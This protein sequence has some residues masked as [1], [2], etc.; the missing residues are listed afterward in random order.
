MT[1]HFYSSGTRLYNT[2]NQKTWI[3]FFSEYDKTLE[4]W[5]YVLVMADNKDFVVL[6][7]GKTTITGS[8]IADKIKNNKIIMN[9]IK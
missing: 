6:G 3:I 7:G 9:Y 4:E 8:Y 5:V 2:T 1:Q